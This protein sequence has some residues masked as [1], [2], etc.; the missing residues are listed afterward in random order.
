M[1][2]ENVKMFYLGLVKL[3]TEELRAYEMIRLPHIGDFEIKEMAGK[4]VITGRFPNSKIS[5]RRLMPRFKA[6]KFYP[7]KSWRDYFKA[8]GKLS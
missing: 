5:I 7:N 6:V 4:S 3:M 1:D 2:E 8:K